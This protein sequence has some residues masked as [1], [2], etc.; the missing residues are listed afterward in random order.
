MRL[1][2]LGLLVIAVIVFLSAATARS[3]TIRVL[4]IVIAALIVLGTLDLSWAYLDAN[5]GH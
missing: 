4:G 5:G 3:D 2:A 1:A